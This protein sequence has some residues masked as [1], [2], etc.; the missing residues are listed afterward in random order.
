MRICAFVVIVPLLMAG[1]VRAEATATT[2]G[3]RVRPETLVLDSPEAA[4]Q[5][6]VF[7]RAKICVSRVDRAGLCLA[8]SVAEGFGDPP[9]VPEFESPLTGSRPAAK[10][11]SPCPCLRVPIR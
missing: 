5:I 7:A 10:R 8:E 4:E 1:M 11:S 2:Q 9:R 6:L 3:L